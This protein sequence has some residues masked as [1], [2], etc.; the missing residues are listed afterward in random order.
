MNL[1]NLKPA[2]RQFQVVNS[3]QSIDKEEILSII[4][5]AESM[6]ANTINRLLMNSVII[7]VLIVCCQGG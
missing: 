2:W 4:E 1:N 3:M 5:R 6:T 7:V